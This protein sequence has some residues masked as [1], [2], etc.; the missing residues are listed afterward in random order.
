[1][2]IETQ[3]YIANRIREIRKSRSMTQEQLSDYINASVQKVSMLE[4]ARKKPTIGDLELIADAFSVAICDL[5]PP[6]LIKLAPGCGAD[7]HYDWIKPD[8]LFRYPDKTK[9]WVRIN[10]RLIVLGWIW[11]DDTGE[12]GLAVEYQ[13]WFVDKDT[14]RIPN[15]HVYGWKLA[16]SIR[17]RRLYDDNAP[18]TMGESDTD[19]VLNNVGVCTAYMEHRLEHT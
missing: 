9:V 15:N 17:P 6:K 16:T 10:E 13:D 14:K 3:Q 4:N 1:M 19:F 5:L 12:S 11:R 7:E 2:K 18:W 8:R